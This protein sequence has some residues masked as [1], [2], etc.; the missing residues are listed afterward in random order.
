MKYISTV[1]VL[2]N[3]ISIS[4]ETA[5]TVDFV[6]RITSP[7][8]NLVDVCIRPTQRSLHNTLRIR[9]DLLLDLHLFTIQKDELRGISTTVVVLWHES[10]LIIILFHN[11]PSNV[12]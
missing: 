6:A 3:A 2:I 12:L 4:T 5:E 9:M 10:S 8:D 11:K 1:F 7:T